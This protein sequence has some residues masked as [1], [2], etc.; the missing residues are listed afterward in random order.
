MK[1]K[2]L[3]VSFINSIPLWWSLKDK[4]SIELS[5]AKPNEILKIFKNG[6]YDIALMPTY[7][8]VKNDF[9]LAA[10]FGVL[11]KGN[12]KSVL[13]FYKEKISEVKKIYLDPNS[14]TSQAM[15]RFLFKSNGIK[16]IKGQKE[17]LRLEK[18]EAQLL[19]GDSA[20][21][22]RNYGFKSM[23][24]ASLWKK[25]TKCCA[26]FALWAKNRKKNLTNFDSLLEE[27][28]E[29]SMKQIDQII[30]WAEQKTEI[31]RRILKNYF[32]KS[33]FYRFGREGIESLNFYNEVF[34]EK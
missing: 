20:L 7:E 2:I 12:V 31:D 13:L 21:K 6:G 5:F 26:L 28:L 11:S 1:T 17:I 33:L 9:V 24:I 3:A 10:P 15:T 22:L 30:N 8:F 16:F 23:D 19:I 34:G 27:G 25:K 14:R 18:D 29:N 32:T 4:K